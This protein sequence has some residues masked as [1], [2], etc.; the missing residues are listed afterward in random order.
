MKIIATLLSL[1][2][3]LA[4]PAQTEP[5]AAPPIP[6]PTPAAAPIA[7]GAPKERTVFIPFD[8][9]A[10]T[11]ANE[12]QGVFLPYREF[13]DMWN[14]LT[15]HKDKEAIESPA[16]SVLSSLEYTGTIVGDVATISATLLVESFKDEGWA[17]LPLLSKGLSISKAETGAATLRLEKN[18][19]ELLLPKKGKYTIKLELMARVERAS[20]RYKLN[21][22]LPRAPVSRCALTL[23][24]QGWDFRLHPVAAY[25]SK[26]AENGATE[27]AFFFGESEEIEITW[28]KQGGEA[29]LTPLVFAEITQNV[30]AGPG[31][32]QNRLEIDYRILR[33]GVDHFKLLIPAPH[34]VLSVAGENVKEWNPGKAEANGMRELT[35]MLHSPARDTFRLTVQLEAPVDVLPAELKIPAIEAKDVVRQRG[36]L[37]L[38][39]PAE[40]DAALKDLTGLNQQEISKGPVAPPPP[41]QLQQQKPPN[42]SSTAGG[43]QASYRY[44]KLP[45]TA[46]LTLKRAEPVVEVHTATLVQASLDTLKFKTNVGVNV[47]RSGIFNLRIKV[48]KDFDGIEAS[49]EQIDS[50]KIEDLEDQ[51]FLDVKFKSR[52]SNVGNFVLTGRQIRKSAEQPI[53][54]PVFEPQ[55]VSRHEA[56]VALALHVSLD[57]NTK[58]PGGLRQE[59]VAAVVPKLPKDAMDATSPMNPPALAFSYRGAA[60]PAT[61]TTRLKQSQVT[62]NILTTVNLKEQTTAYSYKIRYHIQYAGV[63]SF[64][65]NI[66]KSISKDLRVDTLDIQQ[67]TKELPLPPPAKPEKPN[68]AAAD[69]ELWKITLR[70]KRM[71]SFDLNL[72]LEIP[73]KDLAAGKSTEIHVPQVMLHDV[74]QEL[75]QTAITKAGN[76]EVLDS[77]FENFENID[78][79]E[80]PT[81]LAPAGVI[82]CYKHLRHPASLKLSISKNIFLKVPQA[83]VTYADIKTV[84]SSN[85]GTS[86]EV[87]YWVKNNTLQYLQ[88]RLPKDGRMLSDVYVNGEPQQPMR[89]ADN[90][91]AANDVLI[92]IPT[93]QSGNAFPVR[94][95]YEIPANKDFAMS[96]SLDVPPPLFAETEDSK[97][98]VLQTQLTLYLPRNH[99]YLKF[100][101]PMQ[102]GQKDQGWGE[103]HRRLRFLIPVLGADVSANTNSDWDTPPALLPGSKRGFD[104][105]LPTDGTIFKL[106]RLDGPAT[107]TITYRNARMDRAL[108]YLAMIG[109]FIVGLLI[110]R[111]RVEI[112]ALY[113]CLVGL[114]S[115]VLRSLMDS[116]WAS[117][118]ESV[119]LGVLFALM[120]W[121]M[122]GFVRIFRPA[123]KAPPTSTP[124]PNPTHAPPAPAPASGPSPAPAPASGL[125]SIPIAPEA[126]L[127]REKSEPTSQPPALPAIPDPLSP[128]PSIPTISPPAVLPKDSLP[129][130]P[131]DQKPE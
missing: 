30:N 61:V 11:L 54:I 56:L 73:V 32:V 63:D 84:V 68:S 9:L 58:E 96:G 19:Y 123:T 86:T 49:G 5:P 21:L 40:L 119:W 66:P 42:A 43:I 29:K 50:S 65:L 81:D 129:P 127:F 26:P 122:V 121:V 99:V 41:A 111:R 98:G 93:D 107:T 10:K 88:V 45:F 70:D 110:I 51:R 34:E 76:L 115:L 22:I 36:S 39:A 38:H 108:R 46:T 128:P 16:E 102:R 109:A 28:Q 124:N 17:V 18:N 94:F 25:T 118:W 3:P 12:G 131:T 47:K 57:P 6:A 53:I 87:I 78:P 72:S 67:V 31:T 103:L 77:K 113:F 92:K 13:L 74:F 27:L 60:Q 75:G 15:I 120:L 100:D 79:K 114:G 52:L 62:G 116:G 1:L 130:F 55:N 48:P 71:G 91:S 24:D 4:A 112:K 117:L 101:G 2:I 37:L 83:I 97:V 82:L 33:A 23:P 85:S 106:H 20:G 14:Q 64:T 90:T 44:L 95:L 105:S 8:D 104:L 69:R 80:L 125:G 7:A 35:V 59:D 126:P 89:R